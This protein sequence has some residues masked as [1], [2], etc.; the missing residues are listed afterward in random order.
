MQVIIKEVSWYKKY[1]GLIYST[2]NHILATDPCPW[3]INENL[4]T[5]WKRKTTVSYASNAENPSRIIEIKVFL[6]L[7]IL[8]YK[9]T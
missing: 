4:F 8:I 6:F 1:C 3:I 7:F 2:D 5:S 9:K